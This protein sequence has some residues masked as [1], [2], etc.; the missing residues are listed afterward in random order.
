MVRRFRPVV[1][2]GCL[3]ADSWAEARPIGGAFKMLQGTEREW[4]GS[5]LAQQH[6]VQWTHAQL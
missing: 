1:D 2:A 4:S 5:G 3:D 6:I